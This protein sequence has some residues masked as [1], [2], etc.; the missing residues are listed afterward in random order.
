MESSTTKFTEQSEEI[1]RPAWVA[2]ESE[3][4]HNCRIKTYPDG[5]REIMV[6]DRDIFR[7]PGWESSDGKKKLSRKWDSNELPED[8]SELTQYALARMEEAEQQRKAESTARAQ[9]RAKAAV[10]DLGMCNDFRFF[11]TLTL[12]AARVDRYDMGEITRRLNR[13]LDNHVRRDGLAYVLVPE[14]HKDGAV[15]FHGFFNDALEAVDSGT[16]VRADGG[17]PRRPRSAAQRAAW[18]AEGGHVVYNLP[19]W[20]YGFTTAIELYGPRRAAVGY[21][22]KYIGKQMQADDSGAERPGKIGGRWYYSGGRLR[23]PAVECLDVDF[24]DFEAYASYEWV[25]EALGC[26]CRKIEIEGD[27]NDGT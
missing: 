19:A 14:R 9:R 25:I 1:R 3:I 6:A 17:K 15:H 7:A 5:T 22:T 10:R 24:E 21:V 23:R 27:H 16:I 26:K 13:W 18:L 11:V 4:R 12:D 8:V 2:E 20:D